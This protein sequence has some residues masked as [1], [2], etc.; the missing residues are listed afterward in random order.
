MNHKLQL[1]NIE[2][3]QAIEYNDGDNEPRKAIAAPGVVIPRLALE[4]K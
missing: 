2:I 1:N 4:L 3:F